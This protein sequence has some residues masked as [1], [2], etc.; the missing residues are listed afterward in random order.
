MQNYLDNSDTEIIKSLEKEL[1]FLIL[2]QELVNKN[3]LLK[4]YISKS[5]GNSKDNSNDN[6]FDLDTDHKF[7]Q[8]YP[9][10]ISQ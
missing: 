1:E 7:L 3:Q 8:Q 5:F 9:T 4:L 10:F 2:K 6:D